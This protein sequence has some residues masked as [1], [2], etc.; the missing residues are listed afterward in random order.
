M[1]IIH[2]ADQGLIIQELKNILGDEFV[3]YEV[4]IYKGVD[5][6]V[7]LL[8]GDG[9][10]E[11]K[12]KRYIVLNCGFLSD[13][14]QADEA[15]YLFATFKQNR[16]PD[17][18][19]TVESEKLLTKSKEVN[20]LVSNCNVINI[21]RLTNY[22]M[23]NLVNKLL[24]SN[25]IKLSLSQLNMLFGRLVPNALVIANEIDKLKCF[26]NDEL[27]DSLISDLIFEYN[28]DS[29]FKLVE[30]LITRNEVAT[31]RLYDS[32]IDHLYAP[33]EILQI[34]AAQVLKLI[35][36]AKCLHSG[37]KQNEIIKVLGISNFH[38]Y[39]QKKICSSVSLTRLEK[40]LSGILK[41]DIKIKTFNLD[42]K[43]AIRFF[44]AKN[45]KGNYS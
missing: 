1:T 8:H 17:V 28:N 11:P 45:L 4:I 6:L 35:M 33:L 37:M 27:T 7:D 31:I 29:I 14:D 23:Q 24:E 22:N 43:S 34:M 16:L 32:L 9:M 40:I 39:A 5:Q 15:N 25:D 18:Y 20:E 36:M 10:F 12:Q 19:L 2:S 44:L 13:A 41:L 30:L 26:K 3:N 38:F 21:P 42:D